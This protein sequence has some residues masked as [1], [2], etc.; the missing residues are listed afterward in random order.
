MKGSDRFLAGILL[1]AAAGAVVA[2]F[3]KSDKGKEL[4]AS[5]KEHVEDL[6]SDIK[7]R[8]EA[9]EEELEALL[10]KGRSLVNEMENEHKETTT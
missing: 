5:L 8:Y 3:L 2:L 7:T 10:Q 1:G 9:F 6:G 4:V